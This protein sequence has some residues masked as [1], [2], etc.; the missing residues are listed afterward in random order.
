MKCYLTL[1]SFQITKPDVDQFK[2]ETVFPSCLVELRWT[3]GG[4]VP[5]KRLCHKVT[6]KGAKSPTFFHIRHDPRTAGEGNSI[7]G[8]D[9]TGASTGGEV[10]SPASST[11]TSFAQGGAIPQAPPSHGDPSRTLSELTSTCVRIIIVLNV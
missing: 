6:L 2:S 9:Q 10:S 11:M 8:S 3:G 7:I 5:P 4:Q 1:L